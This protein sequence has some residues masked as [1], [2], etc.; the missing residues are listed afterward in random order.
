MA[1]PFDD[2]NGMFHVLINAEEQ[3]SLWPVFCQIP[4]GWDLVLENQNRQICLDYI[5]TNW[6]DMRPKSLKEAMKDIV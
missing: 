2:E 6:T 4:E 3:F 5:K 1:N